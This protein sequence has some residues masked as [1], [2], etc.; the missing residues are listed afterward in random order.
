MIWPSRVTITP[1]P[2]E[3]PSAPE[4]STSTSDGWMVLN[5]RWATGGATVVVVGAVVV[6]AA[7]S[8]S[9]EPARSTT[10]TATIAMTAPRRTHS[11]GRQERRDAA[12][13]A[14]GSASVLGRAVRG[15]GRLHSGPLRRHFVRCRLAAAPCD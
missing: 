14:A 15:T 11:T 1:L 10:T 13:S 6:G 8:E 4:V 12:V 3:L 7:C 5:T 2:S 9:E